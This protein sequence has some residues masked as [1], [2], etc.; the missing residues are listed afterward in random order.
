MLAAE[1]LRYLEEIEPLIEQPP[2]HRERPS[3]VP[4]A[5]PNTLNKVLSIGMVMLCFATASFVVFRYAVIST[6]HNAILELKQVLETKNANQEKLKVEL[7]YSEDL[8]NIE[9]A[10]MANLGMHYPEN[11]QVL[12]IDLPVLNEP[13]NVEVASQPTKSVLSRLFGFAN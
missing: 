13:A 10:A 1:K 8:N 4:V 11:G 7:A 5:K 3:R 2:V 12:Y 9:F 6:N